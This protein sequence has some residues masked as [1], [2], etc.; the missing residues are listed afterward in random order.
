MIGL[1]LCV[2]FKPDGFIINLWE[3]Y[4]ATNIFV[5]FHMKIPTIFC[6]LEMVSF[7][8]LSKLL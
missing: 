3:F 5:A 6:Y 7:W 2:D 1:E 8:R 4:I